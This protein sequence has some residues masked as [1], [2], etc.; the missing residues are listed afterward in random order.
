MGTSFFLVVCCLKKFQNWHHP[1][2]HEYYAE[3]N[4]LGQLFFWNG[5]IGFL[6]SSSCP[7]PL[8]STIEG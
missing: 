6:E 7:A 1:K 8:N 3:I 4:V 2:N 5:L